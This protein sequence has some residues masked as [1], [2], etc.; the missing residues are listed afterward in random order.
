[1]DLSGLVLLLAR[2]RRFRRRL[3]SVLFVLRRLRFAGRD[4]LTGIALGGG[5]FGEGFGGRFLGFA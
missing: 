2:R 3:R 5:L 1:M 4:D